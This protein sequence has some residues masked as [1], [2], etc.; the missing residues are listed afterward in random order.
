MEDKVVEQSRLN[1]Y[2]SRSSLSLGSRNRLQ[3]YPLVPPINRRHSMGSVPN[4]LFHQTPPDQNYQRFANTQSIR[5]QN[6]TPRIVPLMGQRQPGPQM[7]GLENWTSFTDNDTQDSHVLNRSWN[8]ES[9]VIGPSIGPDYSGNM[10]QMGPPTLI[11]G[12]HFGPS[13]YFA[14]RS[15]EFM[16]FR[17]TGLNMSFPGY[18]VTNFM[19]RGFGNPFY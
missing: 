4:P 3:P 16:R 12:P 19:N 2:K 10:N 7:S 14:G 5:A 9:S 18:P 1:E 17:P 6:S 11:R 13:D 15:P 8:G